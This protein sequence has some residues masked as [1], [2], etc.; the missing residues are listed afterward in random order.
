LILAKSVYKIWI[1]RLRFLT[2]LTTFSDTDGGH[3][4]AVGSPVVVQGR[5]HLPTGVGGHGELQ[6][7][8]GAARGSSSRPPC[9]EL[10]QGSLHTLVP[11]PSQGLS[12]LMEALAKLDTRRSPALTSPDSR[13]GRRA[14]RCSLEI[15]LTSWLLQPRVQSSLEIWPTSWPLQPRVQ[16]SLEIWLTSWLLQPYESTLKIR[17][18]SW[19]LQPDDVRS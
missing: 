8:L 15:R 4:R 11:L 19:P 5:V 14:G 12:L 13:F 17:P 1:C 9:P 10:A 16:S 2:I 3:V 6:G 18:K 7:L